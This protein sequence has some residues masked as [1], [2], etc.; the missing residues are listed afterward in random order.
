MRGYRSVLNPICDRL[1]ERRVQSLTRDEVESLVE[2]MRTEGGARRRGWSQRSC[3]YAL[4]A[5]RQVL[6][7][8]VSKGLLAGNPAA[9]VQAPRRQRGDR[10][11]TSVWEPADL[12]AFRR[13]ADSDPWASAWRLTLSGL[14]RSEVLGMSWSCVDTEAGTVRVEA[15]RIVV[16]GESVIDDPKSEASARTVPV[17]QMHP[18]TVALLRS[19]RTHQAADRLAAGLAYAETGLLLVDALGSG[20][21]PDAYGNRFR[22]L[23]RDAA[24]PS[25]PAPQRPTHRGTHAAPCRRGPSRRGSPARP[26]PHYPPGADYVPRTERGV[27]AAAGRF[28]EVLAAVR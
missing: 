17:E 19:L 7:Y 12:V 16:S 21:S 10:R 15:G 4:G 14:R 9:R 28:G 2:W 11:P 27:A 20:V 24:V 18:G 1:G 5:L 3:V 22:A 25:D 6:D 23:C 13:V 8:G 26:H